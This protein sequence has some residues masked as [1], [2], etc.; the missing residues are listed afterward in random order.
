MKRAVLILLLVLV[1]AAPSYS[2][3]DTMPDNTILLNSFDAVLMVDSFAVTITTR[4]VAVLQYDRDSSL[5]EFKS[6]LFFDFTEATMKRYG[7]TLVVNADNQRLYFL[8]LSGL[9]HLTYLGSVDLGRKFADF[10]VY[11]DDVYISEWFD[12]VWRYHLD[13][14][15]SASF[16]DSSMMGILVSQLEVQNDTLYVLD[17]YNGILRYDI[18][19]TGFGE[20][21][22]YL[23]VPFRVNSFLNYGSQICL[24]L[25]SGGASFGDFSQPGGRIVDSIPGVPSMLKAYKTDALLLLLAQRQMYIFNRSDFTQRAVV[26]IQDY[27]LEGD[28]FNVN[29]EQFIVLPGSNGGLSLF[30]LTNNNPPQQGLYRSGV[31]ADMF[32]YGDHLYTSGSASPVD[33]WKIGDSAHVT[34]EYAI[35]PDINAT[36]LMAHNGDSLVVLYPGYD[37]IGVILNASNPDSASLENTFSVGAA[38]VRS[39]QFVDSRWPNWSVLVVDRPDYLDVYVLT[40]SGYVTYINRWNFID[41]IQDYAVKDTFLYVVLFKRVLMTWAIHKDFTLTLVS[42]MGLYGNSFKTFVHDNQL[43]VFGTDRVSVIDITDPPN[44]FTDTVIYLPLQVTDLQMAGDSLYAVGPDGI[45]IFNLATPVPTLVVQGGIGGDIIAAGD[46]IVAVSG[47]DGIYV[48]DLERM[49]GVFPDGPGQEELPTRFALSQNYPN[50]FNPA[51][52]IQFEL[53]KGEWVKLEVFNILGQHVTTPVD[54]YLSA[55]PHRVTFDGSQLASGVYFYR[56]SAGENAAT[57]KMMLVK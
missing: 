16:A 5:F 35:R 10:T 49:S 17:E 9:P 43:L 18:S 47:G 4:G 2:Q 26:D 21:V 46:G 22:D 42:G 37:K 33:V 45:S 6:Q 41:R 55:G 30:D 54:S 38:P 36:S 23:Y 1:G 44:M 27:K 24:L 20:F 13:G 51:T 34:H 31:V 48:Y 53:A 12:G 25:N 14:L 52:V 3:L 56:L 40:D 11:N 8:D 50:P 39:L 29:Y 19:G 15:S 7:D 57:K 32:V 28:F